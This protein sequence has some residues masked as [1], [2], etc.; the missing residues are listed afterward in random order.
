[1]THCAYYTTAPKHPRINVLDTQTKGKA[2][3]EA[4]DLDFNED[5]TR[6]EARFLD[7][8]MS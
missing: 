6:P 7:W 4:Q 5:P 1:M 8:G 2:R 3:L